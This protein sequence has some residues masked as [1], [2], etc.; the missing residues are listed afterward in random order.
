MATGSRVRENGVSSQPGF[1][2]Q[3]LVFE[4]S[5]NLRIQ[6]QPKIT[7]PPPNAEGENWLWRGWRICD[8]TLDKLQGLENG[9]AKGT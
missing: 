3:L 4:N 6:S 2:P 8:P 1:V 9:V 7:L 5:Q